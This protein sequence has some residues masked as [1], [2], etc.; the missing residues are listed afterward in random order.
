M[1]LLTCCPNTGPMYGPLN[2]LKEMLALQIRSATVSLDV[3]AGQP[4]SLDVVTGQPLDVLTGQPHRLTGCSYRSA[5]VPLDGQPHRPTGQTH[6]TYL[7][8]SYTYP[9]TQ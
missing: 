4:V 8:V 5:T 7:Q 3:L 2:I 9:L 6:W 1:D